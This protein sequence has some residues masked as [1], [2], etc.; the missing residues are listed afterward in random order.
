MECVGRN[1][2]DRICAHFAVDGARGQRLDIPIAIGGA[3]GQLRRAIA[4][5][6]HELDQENKSS[7]E[8]A[9]LVGVTQRSVH[10]NRAAHRG[11]KGGKQ[12]RLL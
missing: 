6:V 9:R 4:Q 1:A 10:R 2:A 11:R 3:Y 12:G 5:R 7:R 8:I